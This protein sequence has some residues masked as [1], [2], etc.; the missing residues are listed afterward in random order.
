MVIRLHRA[1]R[2]VLPSRSVLPGSVDLVAPT[3]SVGGCV[4]KNLGAFQAVGSFNYGDGF[5]GL[6][7]NTKSQETGKESGRVDVFHG[8]NSLLETPS[9]PG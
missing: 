6:Y 8:C 2:T 3:G 9:M 7:R 1:G 5:D 4:C